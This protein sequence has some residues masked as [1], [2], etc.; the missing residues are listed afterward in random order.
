MRAVIQRVSRAAVTAR[1]GLMP[2]EPGTQGRDAQVPLAPGME[3]ER[4]AGAATATDGLIGA[5]GPGLVVLLG[6]HR[7]DGPADVDWLADKIVHLRVFADAEGKMNQSLLDTGGAML[8]V[9]QFT[10]HGDCRKGRRPGYS[11]AARPEQAEVLYEDFI[12]AVQKYGIQTAT[13]RFQ[14]DMAVEL[15]NDGPVTLLLDSAKIF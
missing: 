10:L 6:V 4:L 1:D 15:V 3:K 9:S 7:D 12:K 8:I 13:G 5:I 2:R 14:A 11:Q